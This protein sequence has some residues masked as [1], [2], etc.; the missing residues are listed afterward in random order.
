MCPPNG[1]N[2]SSIKKTLSPDCVRVRPDLS[3]EPG[4]R[5]KC[6][7]T[8]SVGSKQCDEGS[9]GKVYAIGGPGRP[10]IDNRL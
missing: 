2:I 3:A 5:R 10:G 1:R 7:E 8:P 9:R 6:L 4:A